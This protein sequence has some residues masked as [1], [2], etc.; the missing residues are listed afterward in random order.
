[1]CLGVGEPEA[2]RKGQTMGYRDSLNICF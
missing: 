2:L 1:L